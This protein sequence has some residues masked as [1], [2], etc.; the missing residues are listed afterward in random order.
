MSFTHLVWVALALVPR[1]AEPEAIELATTTLARELRVEE[2]GL[3]VVRAV[4]VE[5]PDSSLGCPGGGQSS[6]PVIVPGYRVDL[7]SG[8]RVHRVHVGD[9]RA[10]Y[11]RSAAKRIRVREEEAGLI[12]DPPSPPEDDGEPA[13]EGSLTRKAREDLAARL[14]VGVDDIK[15]VFVKAVTWHDASLGCPEEGR[16]Y[17]QVRTRGSI[18]GLEHRGRT[19]EYHTDESR[20]ILCEGRVSR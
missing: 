1:M 15:V 6:L 13:T 14:A 19:Y 12:S 10:V 18:I 4:P 3:E 9:G 5:W 2:E 20:P 16:I 7:K 11:C 8:T 17:A